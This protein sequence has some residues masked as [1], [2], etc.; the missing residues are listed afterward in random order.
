[1]VLLV[2]IFAAFVVLMG[3]MGLFAPAKLVGM[4]PPL[5]DGMAGLWI[6]VG[7]SR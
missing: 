7:L 2:Q 6:A 1:M 3:L 5:F 4:V